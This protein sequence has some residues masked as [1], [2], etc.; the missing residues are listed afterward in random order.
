M[1]KCSNGVFRHH[2]YIRN[3]VP[4]QLSIVL[5]PLFHVILHPI[6]QCILVSR[7]SRDYYCWITKRVGESVIEKFNPFLTTICK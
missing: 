4:L 1:L 7:V 2:L 6:L 3:F 5:C